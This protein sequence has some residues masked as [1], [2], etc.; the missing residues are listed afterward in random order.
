MAEHK[1]F[2]TTID[3]P[4]NPFL[5]YDAWFAYENANG[6]QTAQLIDLFYFGS[7]DVSPELD[8]FMWNDAIGTILDL[9]PWYIR[10]TRDSEIKPIPIEIVRK[11]MLESQKQSK[12]A[13]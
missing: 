12:E 11:I 2:P 9:F 3:N 7:D 10:V 1:Y 13:L 4:N 6:H 8:E 5:D